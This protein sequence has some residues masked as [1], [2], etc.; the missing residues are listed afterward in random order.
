[1]TTVVAEIAPRRSPVRVR[2]APFVSNVLRCLRPYVSGTNPCSG[3]ECGRLEIS[4]LYLRELCCRLADA[5][6]VECNDWPLEA[7]EHELAGRLYVDVPLDLC[8]EPLRNQDLTARR[9][10]GK[11]RGE[12]RHPPDCR[13]VGAALEADLAAGH[14]TERDARAEVEVVPALRPARCE[15]GH[16]LA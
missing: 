4:P 10:A 11:P 14:V 7:L 3:D 15:L 12:V 8:V 13:V 1:M 6:D 16:L 5:N 2:L 9:L